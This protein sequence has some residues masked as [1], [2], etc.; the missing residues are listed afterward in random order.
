MFGID[1][2]Q[3]YTAPQFFQ[4][5]A[6]TGVVSIKQSLLEDKAQETSYVVRT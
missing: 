5:D 1:N 3:Y 4:I 2:N 6:S